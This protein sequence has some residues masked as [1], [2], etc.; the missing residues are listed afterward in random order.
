MTFA[1]LYKYLLSN[2]YRLVIFLAEIV[3]HLAEFCK[4]QSESTKFHVWAS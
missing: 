2:I 1:K 4:L 3:E